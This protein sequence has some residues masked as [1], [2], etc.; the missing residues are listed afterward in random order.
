MAILT[1][2]NTTGKYHDLN[3]YSDVINY[4]TQPSKTIR[5]YIGSIGLDPYNPAG[6]MEAITKQFHKEGGVHV[7]HFVVSFEPHELTNPETA[8]L[9]GQDIISYL[10]LFAQ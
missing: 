7:R 3:S 5:G 10:G 8:S 6:H 4:I 2:P 1:T 9:I